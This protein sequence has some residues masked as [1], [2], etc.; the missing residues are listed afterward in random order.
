[1]N[2]QTRSVSIALLYRLTFVCG[3]LGTVWISAV[4]GSRSGL[5]FALGALV[6]LGNLW[7]F[8]RL[9]KSIEPGPQ[10]RKP[11]QA[12]AFGGRYLIYLAFGYVIVNALGVSPLPVVLGLFS[13]TAAVLLSS[14]SELVGSLFKRR[15]A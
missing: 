1:M 15:D 12:S 7:L 2:L 4:W 9:S 11:W 13:S 14:L 8:H 6:S 10:T 5:A 3:V